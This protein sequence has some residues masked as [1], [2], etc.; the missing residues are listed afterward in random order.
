MRR[1]VSFVCKF[2]YSFCNR[3]ANLPATLATSTPECFR[4]PSASGFC[5]GN[6]PSRIFES[7]VAAAFLGMGWRR[8]G[9]DAR[10][11][12][13]GN[14]RDSRRIGVSLAVRAARFPMASAALNLPA[15]LDSRE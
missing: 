7:S 5:D 8:F 14:L 2:A 10:K 12:I 1:P 11:I 13:H 3:Q 4:R 6:P 15:F 9:P